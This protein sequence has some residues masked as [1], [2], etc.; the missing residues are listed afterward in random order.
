MNVIK[1]KNVYLPDELALV[2]M[3]E[4]MRALFEKH[5][6]KHPESIARGIVCIMDCFDH[7]MNAQQALHCGDLA[8]LI[9]EKKNGQSTRGNG[10]TMEMGPSTTHLRIIADDL[11]RDT[12]TGSDGTPSG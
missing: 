10:E 8:L 4:V 5:K 7:G 9:A 12:S 6:D 3:W 11:P 1:F 2:P